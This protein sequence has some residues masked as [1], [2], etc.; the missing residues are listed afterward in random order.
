MSTLITRRQVDTL[1]VAIT[2][3]IQ[4]TALK[5]IGD[6][7]EQGCE[8]KSVARFYENLSGRI[9]VEHINHAWF[10]YELNE[11]N[12]KIYTV[13]KRLFDIFFSLLGL[14]AIGLIL[15]IIALLIKL[16]S[17]GP[18]I[19]S[20][21]RVGKGGK[22]FKIYKFRSM[23]QNAESGGA[24]WARENDTRITKVGMFLRK[25]RLDELPQLVNVLIGDMS[26]VGPRPER[27]EFGETLS[28]A[29]PFYNRRHIVLPG[30]TGWA[31]IKF[32]YAASIA[33]A[34]EKLQY[35]LYY[36]KN[37]SIFLDLVILARTI[38]V[39]IKKLGR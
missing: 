25:S 13:T 33:D 16:E 5:A 35:D 18:V 39:V 15:P 4:E 26:L 20:Q 7:V 32:P 6:C 12:R 17:N 30:I 37:R 27:P 9:P 23:I 29:I 36:I 34:R 38:L 14:L 22:P 10:A 24:V 19:Y 3:E 8:V 2:H 31:Q 1:V 28:D 11:A 21:V